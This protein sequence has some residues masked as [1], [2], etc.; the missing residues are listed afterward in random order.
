VTYF[1][2]RNAATGNIHWSET[3]ATFQ[4][5]L[6]ALPDKEVGESWLQPAHGALRALLLSSD[7]LQPALLVIA[8][9]ASVPARQ[10][11]LVVPP[12]FMMHSIGLG[13]NLHTDGASP[14]EL[15]I[16]GGR[17]LVNSLRRFEERA[18][19]AEVLVMAA[20]RLAS[21]SAGEAKMKYAEASNADRM[22]QVGLLA[23]P[24]FSGRFISAQAAKVFDKLRGANPSPLPLHLFLSVAPTEEEPTAEAVL[25]A[26]GE[27]EAV[28]GASAHSLLGKTLG[29][30][31]NDDNDASVIMKLQAT[32]LR[33]TP[34]AV[35]AATKRA[36]A[37]AVED[38]DGVDLAT[39]AAR[40]AEAGGA[41]PAGD[42]DEGLSLEESVLAAVPSILSHGIE[43]VCDD[44]VLPPMEALVR[45]T[46]VLARAF[47]LACVSFGDKQQHTPLH[48]AAAKPRGRYTRRL[49]AQLLSVD[50][51]SVART[52]RDGDSPLTL[53]LKR[54]TGQARLA[55]ALSLTTAAA[56]GLDPLLE[57]T[58][59]GLLPLHI[60]A[61]CQRSSGGRLF[62]ALMAE[63][64]PTTI[65]CPAPSSG[66]TPLHCAAETGSHE[67]LRLLLYAIK[68]NAEDAHELPPSLD[69]EDCNGL[70]P[71]EAASSRACVDEF[72]H[73]NP[74]MGDELNARRDNGKARS[75]RSHRQLFG[76]VEAQQTHL[77]RLRLAPQRLRDPVRRTVVCG[78][79]RAGKT[80]FIASTRLRPEPTG[81]RVDK[82]AAQVYCHH[83]ATGG[84]SAAAKKV[85]QQ[86]HNWAMY[87]G[88]ALTVA[89][90]TATAI[91][92]AQGKSSSG[93]MLRRHENRMVSARTQR[94]VKAVGN[95]AG[96]ATAAA[97]GFVSIWNKSDSRE[98]GK[99]KIVSEMELE[100]L[101]KELKADAEAEHRQKGT[102]YE[103][104]ACPEHRPLQEV[105]LSQV[106]SCYVIIID[107]SEPA[108]VQVAQLKAW[109]WRLVTALGNSWDGGEQH[110][111]A[112]A[113]VLVVGSHMD[114][115]G[116]D[117]TAMQSTIDELA[118]RY[119]TKLAITR[120][121]YKFNCVSPSEEQLALVQKRLDAMHLQIK[122]NSLLAPNLVQDEIFALFRTIG[123][124]TPMK[125]ARSL[126]SIA[127]FKDCEQLSEDGL[128]SEEA[129]SALR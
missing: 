80:S 51:T 120:D 65:C 57:N 41:G 47:P 86:S 66:Q 21:I 87:L 50:S 119:R 18:L 112:R 28:A 100:K 92:A 121:V 13:D 77:E 44:I 46:G 39:L 4:E 45:T 117:L 89:A 95:T 118:S 107:A 34:D 61:K 2:R 79:Q 75:S 22:V 123:I 6:A 49:I 110:T 116:A 36:A 102:V 56:Q 105:L 104:T 74:H 69:M 88:V 48:L 58:R 10:L 60:A 83:I 97:H 17:K 128:F 62:L 90:A 30:D 129:Q 43:L 113:Q 82:C 24:L 35:E 85:A 29:D 64:A 72:L 127:G 78:A 101:R 11:L 42:E 38:A 15:A 5:R 23:L 67:S 7:P 14:L 1:L 16:K 32:Q 84:L 3:I 73:Y 59:F 40:T 98:E 53:L 8:I 63:A 70:W 37:A 54:D 52:T 93:G 81:A 106:H 27:G 124:E 125:D 114:L 122:D 91:V 103:L 94:R 126:L 31:D 55:A 99:D 96:A 76:W 108:E 9:L 115:A 111:H 109:L 33:P 25:S 71:L 26:A 20:P 12:L 19:L 68:M